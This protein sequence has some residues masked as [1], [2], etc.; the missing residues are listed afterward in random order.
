[1]TPPPFYRLEVHDELGSTNDEAK[2][3][4]GDGAAEGALIV[5]RRQTAG[6]GRSGRTWTSPEG[7][8]YFSLLLRPARPPGEAAQLSFVAALALAEAVA[9][10]VALKWPNDVLA[11]GR[12]L[13]GILLEGAEAWL[14]IG[15]GINI[16]SAPDGATCLRREGSPAAP[17]DVLDAFCVS[18]LA[19]RSRWLSDGFAPVRTAWLDRAAGLGAPATARVGRETFRGA[20]ADLDEDGALVLDMG[21]GGRRRIAAGEVY[22]DV[23]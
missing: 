15:C 6:R 18:F 2:R 7:N 3:Q 22:F 16:V 14:V 9:I 11:S 10:P 20:F 21:L 5:A 1:M 4:A 13:C 23:A 17:D 8:L 19:W 12:K